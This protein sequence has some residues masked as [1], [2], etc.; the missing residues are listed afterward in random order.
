MEKNNTVMIMKDKII[1]CSKE[2][3]DKMRMSLK[4]KLFDIVEVT[5]KEEVKE[6][7]RQIPSS[8]E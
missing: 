4:I 6:D 7:G 1:H 3:W 8:K 2:V 5:D